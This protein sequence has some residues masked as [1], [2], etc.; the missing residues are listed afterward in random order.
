MKDSSLEVPKMLSIIEK[1]NRLMKE[2]IDGPNCL[3]ESVCRGD[4]CSIKIDTPQFL[5]EKLIDL[6]LAT[7]ENFE[8]GEIYSFNIKLNEESTR[9][10]FFD[11][12]INGCK[13]HLSRFK[14]PQCWIYPTGFFPNKTDCLHYNSWKI[15]NPAATAEASKLLSEFDDFS[16]KEFR[17]EFSTENVRKRLEELQY[18]IEKSELKPKQITGFIDG[19]NTFFLYSEDEFNISISTI[20]SE[21]KCGHEFGTCKTICEQLKNILVRCAK[22]TI[23]T[24]I[25]EKGPQTAYPLYELYE[26]YRLIKQNT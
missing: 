9:C 7:Q 17:M 25:K 13:L 24:I 12:E 23:P 15:T 26:R 20:C 2:S 10:V 11:K 16:K 18:S 4:C 6:G 8:R 1:Y 5:A 3:D 22:S 14:P 21:L 19:W